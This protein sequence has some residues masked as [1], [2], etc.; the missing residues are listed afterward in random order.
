M[1]NDIK[2]IQNIVSNQITTIEDISSSNQLTDEN[3]ASLEK[4][5]RITLQLLDYD[6]KLADSKPKTPKGY[7]LT[8]K[9]LMKKAR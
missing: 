4:L 8:D 3:I 2:K 5:T 6:R 1:S 9:E 7:E